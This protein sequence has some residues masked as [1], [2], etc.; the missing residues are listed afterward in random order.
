MRVI[1]VV[2]VLSIAAL[3]AAGCQQADGPIPVK[4]EEITNRIE[5]VA[6]DLA[7]VAGGNAQAPGELTEDLVGFLE[8]GPG[9]DAAQ[10]LGRRLSTAVASKRMTDDNARKLADR[11]WVGMAARELSERQREEVVNDLRDLLTSRS[12]QRTAID[13]VAAQTAVVQQAV[14]TRPRRWYERF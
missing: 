2:I 14:N 13:S 3:A 7:N 12:V 6:H 9:R 4:N 1:S 8:G 5:D 11:L 10:E